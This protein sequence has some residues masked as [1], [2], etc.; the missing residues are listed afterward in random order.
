VKSEAPTTKQKALI[1]PVVAAGMGALALVCW[2]VFEG[3]AAIHD[4]RP[5]LAQ[6]AAWVIVAVFAVIALGWSLAR[7]LSR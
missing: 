3:I 5:E 4:Y 2:A 7:G 6:F 1:L